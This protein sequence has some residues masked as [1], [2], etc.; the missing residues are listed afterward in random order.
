MG[1]FLRMELFPSN[2][3]RFLDFYIRILRFK[4]TKRDRNYVAVRRDSIEIGAVCGHPE[5]G[6]DGGFPLRRPPTGV[7]IVMEVDDLKEERDYVV[8]A[9]WKLDAD[10]DHQEWGLNDFRIVDPDGYYLRITDRYPGATAE[11]G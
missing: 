10:I 9:G 11:E 5:G 2:M 4:V 6:V 8:A 1:S 7:E 3:D